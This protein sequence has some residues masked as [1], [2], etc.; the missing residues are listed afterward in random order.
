MEQ[1]LLI[2]NA[3]GGGDDKPSYGDAKTR[4]NERKENSIRQEH[5]RRRDVIRGSSSSPK[6]TGLYEHTS[7]PLTDGGGRLARALLLV[8]PGVEA[9]GGVG[10]EGDDDGGGVSDGTLARPLGVNANVRG[11]STQRCSASTVTRRNAPASRCM[12]TA[13]HSVARSLSVGQD[14]GEGIRH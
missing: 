14:E 4:R 9:V 2:H 7:T 3:R 5:H 8:A 13:R 12:A 10:T 1:W 6:S 11:R